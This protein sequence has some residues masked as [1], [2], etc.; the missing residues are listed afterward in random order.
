MADTSEHR[1]TDGVSVGAIKAFLADLKK[2]FPDTYTEM[3]TEDA[4][5]QLVVPRTQ[6]D[7]CAYVEQLRKQSPH[8]H[9][10]KATV[11]VSHAWRY[12]I[13]DVLN[14]LLEFAEE[15][16]VRKEDSKPVFFWFDL[17][18][19]NQNANI[20][21]N[22]PQEWWSTTFKES[23]ANIGRVL[24]VLMP[25]RDPVPLTRA[26]CLWEIFCGVS[27]EG[28]EVSIRLP[29]SEESELEAAIRESSKSVMDTL[30]LVQAQRAEAFNP[31]DKDMIFEAIQN[32]VGF[33]ALN[34]A[35]KDQLRAWCLSKMV[36][37]VEAMQARGED[38]TE[39]FAGLCNHVGI[40]LNEFSEHDRAIA[41]YQRALAIW[42]HT[43]GV[44]GLNVAAVHNNLGVAYN[45][46]GK[47]DKAVQHHEQA[48]AI[49][50]EM[51]GETHPSTADTYNNLGSGYYCKGEY[52][53]AIAYYKKDLAITVETLGKT[54][55]NTA[56]CYGSLG[57]AYYSKGD[58]DTAIEYSKMANEVFVEALGEKHP[59]TADT[60]SSM[61]N[62][63]ADKRQYDLA[64]DCYEKSLEI[65]VEVLG[66][67]HTKTADVHNNLGVVFK[68][69]GE[70]DRAIASYEKA[71]AIRMEILGERHPHT[72]D[73]YNNIGL[74]YADKGEY[75]RAI[76]YYTKALE[77]GVEVLGEKHPSIADSYNNMGNAHAGIGE[78]D[79]A[80]GWYERALAI[81]V[82]MLGEKH[83]STAQTYN[84]VAEAYRNQG[85]YDTAIAYHEK[86]LDIKVA[87]LGEK[88]PSTAD[89]YNNMG[90]AYADK[91]EHDM[92]I[93]C[94][95]KALAIK[96]EV[97]GEKHPSTTMTRGNIGLLH[98]KRS[99][100]ERVDS[101]TAAVD[102]AYPNTRKVAR[103]L[104]RIRGDSDGGDSEHD[105]GVQQQDTGSDQVQA[106]AGQ[107]DEADEADERQGC[108]SQQPLVGWLQKRGRRRAAFRPCWCKLDDSHFAYSKSAARPPK[109]RI[110]LLD[111]L[112]A[113]LA[114]DNSE[115]HVAVPGRTFIFRSDDRSDTT[116]AEW[117]RAIN[118]CLN[119]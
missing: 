29:K 20:T 111:V 6:Q 25:W 106:L 83:P 85:K 4:C 96:L 86:S 17:F 119:E 74:A 58:Y 54:H 71:L 55:P 31:R 44:K 56:A 102:S 13:A 16:R 43:E 41:Y 48:L 110:S 116:L 59:R 45:S 27:N 32:G 98:E 73:S 77:I 28:T 18:M 79:R 26:W 35:V 53:R 91:G 61:G 105:N 113:E 69:K 115:L 1:L 117:C 68:S 104:R 81:K 36:A 109:R 42:L 3:T 67:Q 37:A 30:V 107:Q 93:D 72:A 39:V 99:N 88:H 14:V 40:V 101:G 51:L 90:N 10:G 84:N 78:C 80:I 114:Q 47:L 57:G 70:Y 76:A 63:Y 21:A 64:V 60:Y 5:K 34:Q 7:N 97:L 22:L 112:S 89:S 12:K 94:Y 75:D 103:N 19:N 11:F 50:V 100:K 8:E 46:K 2:E 65:R 52:D 62:A 23:I 118:N 15:Q 108:S 82:D 9:V 49:N 33:G 87:L 92:A 95:E 66:Q 38:K 24:L